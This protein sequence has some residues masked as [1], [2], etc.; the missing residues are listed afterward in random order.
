MTRVRT[1]VPADRKPRARSSRFWL[2]AAPSDCLQHPGCRQRR[3]LVHDDGPS[4]PRYGNDTDRNRKIKPPATDPSTTTTTVLTAEILA[5][6]AP[7]SVGQANADVEVY[8]GPA[9]G[10]TFSCSRGS[11]DPRDRP[12]CSWSRPDRSTAGWR[13]P[14]RSDRMA[15]PDGCGRATLICGCS[16]TRSSSTCPIACSGSNR[17]TRSCWKPRWRSDRRTIRR[18]TGNYFV[19]DVV[20]LTDPDRSL[21]PVC[22]RALGVL[23]HDHR[24][25]RRRRDHRHP[26]HQPPGQH[27][28]AGLAWLCE[29]AQRS[30]G[31]AGRP[32]EA[33]N[34]RSRSGLRRLELS[35]LRLPRAPVSRGRPCRLWAPPEGPGPARPGCSS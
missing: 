35:G 33:G 17:A 11:D 4:T 26:R 30:G 6:P 25:Q 29:S 8:D 24:I 13:C 5:Q 28:P 34:A 20:E 1:L 16:I 18:P 12:A 32:G 9:V 7:R 10:R 2:I 22:A 23:G 21:G 31:P 19:T 14:F 3:R 27:R 15:R